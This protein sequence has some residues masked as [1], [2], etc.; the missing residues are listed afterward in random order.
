MRKHARLIPLVLAALLLAACGT[1]PAA[2]TPPA[3]SVD[4]SSPYDLATPETPSAAPDP[5]IPDEPEFIRGPEA[6]GYTF[7]SEELGFSLEI[8][9][10][11]A[12]YIGICRGIPGLMPEDEAC[13][14]YFIYGEEGQYKAFISAIVAAE[15][16]ELFNPGRYFNGDEHSAHYPIAAS[17]EYVYLYQ[18]GIGGY[19]LPMPARE[20]QEAAVSAVSRQSLSEG[21]VISR[22]DSLPELTE[23]ALREA[24][25]ELSGG[26][27][28]ALSR[29]EAARLVFDMLSAENKG[30]ARP[31][32][33]SDVEPGTDAAA[34]IAYLDSYGMFARYDENNERVDGE[35][36][37]PDEDISRA[38]FVHLLQCALFAREQY[39][40]YPIAFGDPIP[41]EDLGERTRWEYMELD[42]AWKDGWLELRDGKIRPDE[43]ITRAEAARALR[44]AAGP[45]IPETPYSHLACE[46]E[47]FTLRDACAAALEPY[48]SWRYFTAGEGSLL[49][50]EPKEQGPGELAFHTTELTDEGYVFGELL[51]SAWI[52]EREPLLIELP[53]YGDFTA[54][55]ISLTDEDGIEHRLLLQ[56]GG[57]GPEEACPYIITEL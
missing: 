26:G 36:F 54:Y 7:R 53:F 33:F 39:P 38:E 35:L 46:T 21:L 48:E 18:G 28:D 11:A 42:R 17:E 5:D 2:E 8:P 15:R 6:G 3:E 31:L 27:E 51:Y 44:A 45:E 12:P 24:A 13:S 25:A 14:F 43:P 50:L 49:L 34:A 16:D 32:R 56:T 9:D 55:G 19:D 20:G 52:S 22:P 57:M 30:E 23:E 29:A 1:E 4:P 41:A 40:R 37:R 47:W 10:E